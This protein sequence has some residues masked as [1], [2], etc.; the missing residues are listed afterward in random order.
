MKWDV[1]KTEFEK[2]AS[3]KIVWLEGELSKI[4]TGKV[5]SCILE[6]IFVDY[7]A[8]NSKIL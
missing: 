1:Y 8:T 3:E 2:K 5:S 7:F 6:D 4:R